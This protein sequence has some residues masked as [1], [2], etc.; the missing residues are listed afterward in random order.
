[1]ALEVAD[2]VIAVMGATGAGK[3]S[4][5]QRVTG[6]RDILIGHSLASGLS[7]DAIC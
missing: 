2:V 4:Y 7:N 3:S 5:I 6:R 1:M